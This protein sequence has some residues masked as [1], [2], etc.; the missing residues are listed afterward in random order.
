MSSSPDPVLRG[1]RASAVTAA[2]F[3]VD[4]RTGAPV[5]HELIQSARIAAQAA[6]YAEGWAQG[7]RAAKVASRAALDQAAAAER[8]HA[9]ARSAA[10]GRAL[11]ALGT[12]ASG[13]DRRIAQTAEELEDAILAA[14]V[15]LAEAILDRELSTMDGRALDAA[16]RAIALAPAGAEILVRLHPEDHAMLAEDG[17]LEIHGRPVRLRPDPTL[18]PGDAVAEYGA[19][20]IDAGLPAA[21]ARVRRVL[22][23]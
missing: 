8:A 11:A 4:L 9:T 7:Q 3:D 17:A 12:A 20:T 5:P 15:E 21:L 22:A 19:T 16:R 13:L 18:R 14:A 2:R 10:L 6:G 1:T 23:P